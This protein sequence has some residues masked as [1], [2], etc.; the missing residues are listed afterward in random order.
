MPTIQ[1]F[2][3][4]QPC[5][6][7]RFLQAILAFILFVPSAPLSA[8]EA[9]LAKFWGELMAERGPLQKQFQEFD[10]AGKPGEAMAVAEKLIAIDRQLLAIL[11]H[12]E[13]ERKTQ[14]T[15]R[16]E[17]PGRL[18]W[19]IRAH[20]RAE[21]WSAAAARQGEL[22]NLLGTDLGKT[23]YR[24]VDAL[25]DQVHY[26]RLASL[27]PEEARLLVKV[28][29]TSARIHELYGQGKFTEAIPLEQEVVQVQQRLLGNA[30]SRLATSLNDLALLNLA[31]G[32]YARA[33]PLF[34][35]ALEIRKKVLGENHPDYAASLN[36]LAM[37]CHARG[38]YVGAEA[39]FRQAMEIWK[40]ALGE[41][42]PDF[43][44]SL[45][46][47]A[48]LYQDQGDYAR[49]TAFP[50]G[51]GDLEEGP[52]GKPSLLCHQPEQSSH[53]VPGPRRL[54]SG[55]TALPPGI[56]NLEKGTGA[57]PP[58]L[59]QQPEQSGRAVP[60]PRRLRAG[61]TAI[62][63]GIGDLQ[64]GPRGEPPILCHQSEQSGIAVP[65]PR[66]LRASGTALASGSGDPNEN[67]G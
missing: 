15:L 33:K 12:S 16:A 34:R 26:Q 56:R 3:R 30:S 63:P 13:S 8:A 64:E 54:C 23:D 18:G 37:L 46:N 32:D 59:C 44:R 14:Q 21:A 58:R 19:L 49:G 67:P 48:I 4:F 61:R 28:E 60:G 35:Q 41:N 57:E 27:K 29:G 6:S 51:H 17:L 2:N 10:G 7:A 55:R 1:S 53:F 40:K 20:L 62:P 38:D 31:Q 45:N 22:A 42:H 11:P 52:R 43:G 65:R 50:T 24:S 36:E 25:N 66:R 39:L 5:F 9:S 47:L